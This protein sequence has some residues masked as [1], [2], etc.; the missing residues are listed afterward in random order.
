[1]STISPVTIQHIVQVATATEK[2]QHNLQ[3]MAQ[4]HGQHLDE[5]RK[6]TD[7]LK[8]LSVQNS[9]LSN[10]STQVD[11]DKSGNDRYRRKKDKSE[12]NSQID[13]ETSINGMRILEG[14]QGRT[15]NVVV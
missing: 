7:E 11:P 14:N 5:E 3:N 10:Q 13:E 15:I 2:V 12:K 6:T 1:M 4:V 9:E 8:R